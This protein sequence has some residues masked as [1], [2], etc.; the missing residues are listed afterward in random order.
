MRHHNINLGKRWNGIN[1]TKRNTSTILVESVFIMLIAKCPVAELWLIWR[2][3]D[4][5]VLV[6]SFK[7]KEKEH[8]E[9]HTVKRAPVF[10]VKV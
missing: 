1:S 9:K 6:I 7:R 2:S 4:L 10:K 5:Q 8:K 3:V